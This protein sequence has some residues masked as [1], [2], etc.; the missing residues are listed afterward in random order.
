MNDEDV[1]ITKVRKGKAKKSSA[2]EKPVESVQGAKEPLLEGDERFGIRPSSV[3]VV[4][5][6]SAPA[7]LSNA[8]TAVAP[9][10]EPKVEATKTRKKSAKALAK[11]EIIETEK[12]L[13][14]AQ[15]E[16]EQ[17]M[18]RRALDEI[19][20]LESLKAQLLREEIQKQIEAEARGE[21]RRTRKTQ[22]SASAEGE[23]KKTTRKIVKDLMPALA[24]ALAPVPTPAPV[25]APAP[26]S[27]PAQQAPTR[28]KNLFS[29][30]GGRLFF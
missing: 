15:L 29:Q 3:P 17:D 10:V 16:Q 26:A 22:K 13:K 18:R 11:E 2:L 5:V 4:P 20:K 8:P 14:K 30:R 28:P 25:P 23:K 9:L 6:S 21:V 24:P 12:Q 7:P 19:Q 1:I 27:T